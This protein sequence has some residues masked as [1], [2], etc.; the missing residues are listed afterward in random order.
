MPFGQLQAQA[1]ADALAGSSVPAGRVAQKLV[2]HRERV[3]LTQSQLAEAS[4]ISR[5]TITLIESGHADPKLST[6][7][8][9]AK[10]LGIQVTD[11]IE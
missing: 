3:G 9:L 2:A 10:A 1:P 7:S 4:H 8:L 5:A 6:L 11:L